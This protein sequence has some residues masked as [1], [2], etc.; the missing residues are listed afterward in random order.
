MADL[1]RAECSPKCFRFS[2]SIADNGTMDVDEAVNASR[3]DATCG[4]FRNSDRFRGFATVIR[5]S[6]PVINRL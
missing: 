2:P 6:K 1:F 5:K 3:L 4:G